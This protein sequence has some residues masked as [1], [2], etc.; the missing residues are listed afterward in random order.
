MGCNAEQAKIKINEILTR[1]QI[2][3]DPKSLELVN[4]KTDAFASLID[5]KIKKQ[6]VLNI[7][8]SSEPGVVANPK[9]PEFNKL[10]SYK[11]GQKNMTYA[12]IGSRETSID[13][14][15]EM[16]KIAK[17]LES[18]GYVGQ[19]GG[20][21][22]ADKAFEGANQ[23]WEKEDGT[24]A[25]TKEFTKSK[26]NVTKWARYSD[27]KNTSSKFV[28]FKASDS[29]DKVRNIAKEIHPK[30]Q[31][32]SDKDGLDLHARNT[33]QVFGK[34]LDTPVDFVLFYAEEQKDSIRPKGGTGQ[35][36]EMARLKGIPT[37][38]MADKNWR[39][40][41]DNVLSKNNEESK[42][43]Y[44]KS[45]KKQPKEKVVEKKVDTLKS[46][47]TDVYSMFK[48]LGVNVESSRSRSLPSVADVVSIQKQV[49]ANI[50]NINELQKIFDNNKWIKKDTSNKNTNAYILDRIKRASSKDGKRSGADKFEKGSKE[51]KSKE[52]EYIAYQIIEELNETLEQLLIDNKE[53]VDVLK[54]QKELFKITRF[55]ADTKIK[56][57]DSTDDNVKYLLDKN[58]NPLTNL[59]R[60]QESLGKDN[61][62]INEE[63]NNTF[64]DLDNIVSNQNNDLL[65]FKND[66]NIPNVISDQ[67]FDDI[68]KNTIDMSDSEKRKL[69]IDALENSND[70]KNGG[71]YSENV[72]EDRTGMKVSHKDEDKKSGEF[73]KGY[74]SKSAYSGIKKVKASVL[75]TYKKAVD[76]SLDST[77]GSKY[78]KTDSAVL[79]DIDKQIEDLAQNNPE[80]AKEI[81]GDSFVNNQSE[82]DTFNILAYNRTKGS[83]NYIK[84]NTIDT[85][86]SIFKR[87]GDTYYTKNKINY[88]SY[89]IPKPNDKN[90][91]TTRNIAQS[92]I[93]ALG[94]ELSFGN[95]VADIEETYGKYNNIYTKKIKD[96]SIML[97]DHQLN[98][99]KMHSLKEWESIYENDVYLKNKFDS[100]INELVSS[101][102]LDKIIKS[103]EVDGYEFGFSSQFVKDN[104]ISVENNKNYTT[105]AD[106]TKGSSM[107]S[108]YEVDPDE[109]LA[110]TMYLAEELYDMST[111]ASNSA[112]D[113]SFAGLASTISDNLLKFGLDKKIE[114]YTHKLKNGDRKT[115]ASYT[116]GEYVAYEYAEDE[117]LPGG[118]KFEINGGRIDIYFGEG[119]FEDDGVTER[120]VKQDVSLS[121]QK[122]LVMHEIVHSMI[123]KAVDEDNKLERSLYML[124][125][126]AMK[127]M[128]WKD[129][130]KD[131]ESAKNASNAEIQLA[132]DIFGYMNNPTEFL[133]YA[134]TNEN[135][136]NAVNK[137]K[138]SQELIGRFT[139]KRGQEIGKMKTFLNRVIDAIN[140]VYTAVTTSESARAEINRIISELI[141]IN[142][143][144]EIQ[145]IKPGSKNF[146]KYQAFGVGDKFNKTNEWLVNAEEGIFKK[147]KELWSAD[148]VRDKAEATGRFIESIGDWRHLQWLRDSRII[149][150]TVTDIV[151]DTTTESVAWFYEAIR[152]IKGKREKDK[153]DFASVMKKKVNAEF[154]EFDA[155][156][157]ESITFMLQGDWKA[158]GVSIEEYRNMLDDDSIIRARVDELK[159]SINV[160][161][162]SNQAAMLG[163]YIVNG[164]AK[165][166]AMMKNAHQIYF[167]YHVGKI[168]S[169]IQ[170]GFG[171]DENIKMIDELA[172]LYALLYTE[173]NVKSNI[174]K[175]IDRDADVVSFASD[176][177]YSYRTKEASGQL[178]E[179]S[180]YMDK[181]YVRKNGQVD[182][183]FDILPESKIIKN[184]KIAGLNH[185][186]VRE[187][188]DIQKMLNSNEKYF[189][190]IERDMD[191][192]RTQGVLDDISVIESGQEI[193]S[194]GA[195]KDLTY[196]QRLD[197]RTIRFKDDKTYLNE[198]I[199]DSLESISNRKSYS[200][201]DF[202]IS[203]QI[204]G[205]SER[206]SEA[207][208]L[209]YGRVNNDISDILGN[210]TSH[211]QSKEK[212]LLNNQR[213]VELLIA[214]SDTNAGKPG[215]VFLSPKS[216]S[217]EL[218]K[219][220]AMIPDYS[221]AQIEYETTNKGIW[222]KQSRINNIVG[223]K[224]ISI[225]NL[226]L[227]G[228]KLEDYPQW[229]KAIRIIEYVWMELAKS[230]KGIIVKLMPQVV[231]SNA[232]SNMIV[233][234]RHGIG[235]MEYALAFK[236]AWSELDDYLQTN[237]KKIS[238]DIDRDRG[239]KGLDDQ[240]NI[241]E[242][243]LERNG[244][245]SLI[246]DGQFSMIFE[247]LDNDSPSKSTH[248]KDVVMQKTEK[249]FGKKATENLEEIRQN[250]YVTKDT[251]AHR[252]IEKL[253]IFND[254]INKKIIEDKML[255][256][257]KGMTFA[258]E[259]VK[260]N[261]IQGIRNYL[262]QLFTNYS[263]LLN[264]NVKW[265]T[266]MLILNFIKYFLRQGKAQLS[267]SRRVPLGTAIAESIDTFV[268]NMPDPID[269]Y[270]NIF[271]TLGNKIG[272]TPVEMVGGLIFPN[273][274]MPFRD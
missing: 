158:L 172:S 19:S 265:M 259:S 208:R 32:L 178:G 87:S 190:V 47:I 145:A 36:V 244:F 39:E 118:Y 269:Q 38:N 203:G 266:D 261:Y 18:L 130:F 63:L 173:K 24:I 52:N 241:L 149:S 4:K 128:S 141:V 67:E 134:A 226:K 41:L 163:Y 129:F 60:V 228:F 65:S 106:I 64:N 20:A 187:R 66:D 236:N 207:D 14:Q 192:A 258:S 88:R 200:V 68:K 51:Y 75:K 124:K 274:F 159:K 40:Q 256:D 191:P 157:R 119:Y 161:E 262:D 224:D 197:L 142:T 195:G 46:E 255:D 121:T 199:D 240:I 83:S 196:E 227:F 70:K 239:V 210:T 43:D 270:Q 150:D 215:Y 69:Y 94:S 230:Y 113:I 245:R 13:I 15:K 219:Y 127:Q 86:K 217:K 202:D 144:I 102:G 44:N 59:T 169:P 95:G 120:D 251:R 254:I 147:A 82:E 123:E 182:M 10:P 267:M 81:F 153:I 109:V 9:T 8:E 57:D 104:E 205:Y 5:N 34:N 189:M 125:E 233:A 58:G 71:G 231:A 27:G 272:T 105:D 100:T 21:P 31:D 61:I 138:L 201:A 264:V 235:P 79:L 232:T 131:E 117:V 45:T 222:V 29:N 137:V 252:A 3:S 107:D 250:I 84:K 116:F 249:L 76:K 1:S 139:A 111:P 50:S 237:E 211:I 148:G 110:S 23:P 73:N 103:D 91:I 171:I 257:M 72:Q 126:Q 140:K 268:W 77:T 162:Y 30:K 180:K 74:A 166:S 193:N 89:R 186:I 164:E 132:K 198:Y 62:N 22:G 28:V 160:A 185:K 243:R 170:N 165:G 183:K 78:S 234:M 229:Q 2:D 135:I 42:V 56:A 218:Q 25:G 204:T 26:A 143:K 33:F 238:L 152:D 136:F 253:T 97:R 213:F 108:K 220:W 55:G 53:A 176:I 49:L 247:D 80:L 271:D 273:I 216:K 115:R 151:E 248:V 260:Q 54:K 17:E 35:A 99:K 112:Y 16:Y 133:A 246:N 168:G 181:G 179:F 263:Y 101:L 156:E 174:A 90:M 209:N 154:K 225:S 6:F 221:R 48:L 7:A 92:M 177:Y 155:D 242:K 11:E 175:A 37:I 93:K 167:R 98:M 214:D 188:P 212:A 96:L 184:S 122:E 12:G 85:K 114:V 146:S 206:I 223:Y 194:F